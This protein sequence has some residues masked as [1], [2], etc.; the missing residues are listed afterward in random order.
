MDPRL[1]ESRVYGFALEGKDA[2]DAFV[3]TVERF[4]GH[5]AF[6]RFDAERELA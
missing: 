3:D 5:E 1:S 6:E 4:V 2:E